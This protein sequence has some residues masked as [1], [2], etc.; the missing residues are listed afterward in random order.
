M[1]L[2]HE[3]IEPDDPPILAPTPKAQSGATEVFGE[4][5]TSEEERGTVTACETGR[6]V[7]DPGTGLQSRRSRCHEGGPFSCT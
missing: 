6:S 5:A 3:V 1:P 2:S 4:H 7:V